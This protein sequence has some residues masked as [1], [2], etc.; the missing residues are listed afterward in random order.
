MTDLTIHTIATERLIP[1][2]RNARTHSEEQIAQIMAS[3]AEFGFINPILVDKEH[4][5]IAG[6]G[7]LIGLKFLREH[8]I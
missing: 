5:I 3:I 8:S 2:A 1:Y 7:R 6:H 4:G